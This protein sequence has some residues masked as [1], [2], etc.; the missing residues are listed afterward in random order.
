MNKIN[1]LYLLLF[2]V[3]V[4]ALMI[5]KVSST[6]SKIA[7]VAQENAH[8][9]AD[10][11]LIGQLK[12]RWKDSVGTQKRI[13]SILGLSHFNQNVTKRDKTKTG[14]KIVVEGLDNTTLDAFTN[15]LLNE[16]IA[17]KSLEIERFSESNATVSVECE[18]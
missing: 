17:I 6:E 7:Q 8:A 2:F 1:P 4:A 15:K 10:G 11:K 18:L 12:H 5:Y 16:A 13:D 3:M 14:Y 9:E